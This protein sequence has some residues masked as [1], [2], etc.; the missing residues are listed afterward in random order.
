MRN[1][2]YRDT[3]GHAVD[4]NLAVDVLEVAVLFQDVIATQ[5]YRGWLLAV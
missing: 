2:T 3:V 1:I 5:P 4:H